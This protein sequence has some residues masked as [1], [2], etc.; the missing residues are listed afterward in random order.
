MLPIIHFNSFEAE[1]TII[2]YHTFVIS[3][4]ISSGLLDTNIRWCDTIENYNVINLGD[5]RDTLTIN[6]I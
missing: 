2:Y 4:I 6:A 1:Y 3:Q 5:I